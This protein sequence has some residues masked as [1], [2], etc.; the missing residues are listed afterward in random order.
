MVSSSSPAGVTAALGQH[1]RSESL[2]VF[3]LSEAGDVFCQPL[4]HQAGDCRE[5]ASGSPQATQAPAK[6][7][8]PSTVTSCGRWL[9]ASFRTWKWPAAP[10]QD[11]PR[12]LSQDR[13]FTR[14]ELQEPV[15]DATLHGRARQHL[16]E[17]RR[18][19]RLL[20]P[21]ES[22]W[23]PVPPAQEP[24]V[25]PEALGE[26]LA[27][28]WDGSWQSWWQEKLGMTMAQKRQALRAQRRRLKRARGT[29][30]L[31]GS[32]TSSTSYQSDLSSFSEW[33]VGAEGGGGSSSGQAPSEVSVGVG[34]EPLASCTAMELPLPV[35]SLPATAQAPEPST[36]ASSQLLSSQTLCSRGI[37]SERRQTLR[38]Y[39]ALCTEPLGG[40][41][42]SQLS[43][44]GSQR[45]IPSSQGSQPQRK[46]A[47]MGF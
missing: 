46:R 42:A 2:L 32:F 7:G 9:R 33:S 29:R 12:V 35:P 5:D 41:P 17:A 8:R 34:R 11:A 26:R 45:S 3:Q 20:G 24:Q 16:Q 43:S 25:Q 47:R 21:W 36:Q 44:R 40:L 1:G 23:T 19:K 38:D 22:A 31:S 28:S 4:L 37:P 30:S 27:A 10:A 18:E 14:H 15:R 13:L 6:A 39:L